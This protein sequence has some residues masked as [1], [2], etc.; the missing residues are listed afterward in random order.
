M[1][2]IIGTFSL[3]QAMTRLPIGIWSQKIRSRKTPIITT[4]LIMLL[5][6]LPMFIS[7]NFVSIL[8]SSIGAGVFAATFGLQNQYWSENWN[9]RNVY[10]TT[11]LI[12]IMTFTAKYTTR[13]IDETVSIDNDSI[14]W[15]LLSSMIIG[16][17]GVIAYGFHKENK[18]TIHL[19]NMSSVSEE[20]TPLKLKHVL[21]MAFKV[22]PVVFALYSIQNFVFLP[23]KNFD[24]FISTINIVSI[25]V[26]L[27]V[28]FILIRIFKTKHILAFSLGSAFIGILIMMC[29]TFGS[30]NWVWA[31]IAMSLIM[32]GSTT[33]ITT[34]FANVLHFDHKNSLLVLGIWLSIRSFAIGSTNIIVGEIANFD[35]ASVKW[36]L[37]PMFTLVSINIIYS[38]S[39]VDGTEV[40][41]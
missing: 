36:L 17:I 16:F 39:K 11:G 22:V 28:V 21:I 20:I 8:F 31:T 6:T 34:M 23:M 38:V 5:L 14:I 29:T 19:D 18:E 15:I 25:L 4:F 24:L 35:I 10:A 12:L 30:Y 32:I 1:P 3:V 37:I 40:V 27:V 33:Y 26:S 41:Y 7:V 2:I 13:I 9:I